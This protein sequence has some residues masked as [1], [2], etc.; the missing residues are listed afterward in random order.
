MP[1]HD[2]SGGCAAP[3]VFSWT[4]RPSSIWRGNLALQS[5]TFKISFSP[6]VPDELQST[7]GVIN[8]KAVMA[9]VVSMRG[10]LALPDEESDCE[11]EDPFLQQI[12]LD[13]ASIE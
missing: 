10:S 6:K 7:T 3:S 11:P 13:I 1:I 4:A 12:Q 5:L 8:L 2:T 9:T